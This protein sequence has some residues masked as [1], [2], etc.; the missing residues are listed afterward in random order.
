[1]PRYLIEWE[2][3]LGAGYDVVDVGSRN[4]AEGIARD[5]WEAQVDYNREYGAVR[6]TPENLRARGLDP[7]TFGIEEQ[8]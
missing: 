6:A 3:G 5:R 4:R 7:A 2:R 8:Q 1:M